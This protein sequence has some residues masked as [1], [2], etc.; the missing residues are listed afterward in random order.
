MIEVLQQIFKS[1]NENINSALKLANYQ[2]RIYAINI[3]NYYFKLFSVIL[4]KKL[5]TIAIKIYWLYNL[6][7]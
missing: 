4:S 7:Q 1:G 2:Q 6:F 5:K 3:N